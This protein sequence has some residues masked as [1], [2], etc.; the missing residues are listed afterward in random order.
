MALG[1]DLV[2]MIKWGLE[3]HDRLPPLHVLTI[4]IIALTLSMLPILHFNSFLFSFNIS[5]F[6]NTI[7]IT[8]Q[9]FTHFK[10]FVI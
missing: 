10:C 9:L 4:I 6:Y 5:H 8:S 2:R 1:D 7:N 3:N